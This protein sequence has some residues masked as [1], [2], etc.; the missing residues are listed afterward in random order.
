MPRCDDDSMHKHHCDCGLVWEHPDTCF[1]EDRLHKCPGCGAE[2]YFKADIT[3]TVTV[4]H[5]P[6]SP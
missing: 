4:C 3:L 6:P 5:W 1:G 2:E